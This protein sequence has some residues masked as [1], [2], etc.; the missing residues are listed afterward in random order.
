VRILSFVRQRSFARYVMFDLAAAAR[1]LDWPVIWF[2]LEGRLL[3]NRQR[4]EAERLRVVEEVL[5]E[6][7]AF[8]PDLVFS[9]GL[10]YLARVFEDFVPAAARRFVELLDKPSAYFIF[11]F[12]TPFDRPVDAATAPLIA[13][14]QDHDSAMFC[15]DRDALATL[16]AYGIPRAFYFPMAVN[17][18]MF[19]PDEA[20]TADPRFRSE[21]VFVGGPTPERVAALEPL[22]TRGLRVFGYDAAGWRGSAA[23][24]PCYAGVVLERG[25]AR[26]IYSGARI[27]INVTRSHGPSSL[28]MRVYESMACGSL[29]LTDD[30]G[31][32]RRLFADGQEIV[33]YR[34]ASDLV[35]KVDY[36]LAHEVERQAIAEA[37]RRRVAESH[38]YS[39]RLRDYAPV[40]TRFHAESVVLRRLARLAG[41]DHAAAA[42][43]AAELETKGRIVGAR[44]ML[45]CLAGRV[46]L[47]AGDARAAEERARRVL[48]AHPGHLHAAALLGEARAG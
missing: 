22:A 29:L 37:G 34:G 48:A 15:W 4:T 26:R 5:R 18:E 23:L 11:D 42:A 16:K 25:E 8:A 9:Y 7:E 14:L 6:I 19:F 13:A 10:E 1:E 33:V 28:N 40:L 30:R 12:G 36:Y 44:D 41:E 32:A 2:D 17:P 39:R 47:A 27:S 35:A 21:I 45:D 43:L 3:E 38:T 20:A 24:A 46:S 31:D